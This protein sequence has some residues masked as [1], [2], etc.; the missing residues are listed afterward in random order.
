MS[1]GKQVMNKVLMGAISVRRIRKGIINETYDIETKKKSF[2][3]RVF[4]KDFWKVKKEK[5]LYD[6]IKKKAKV[7]VPKILVA[8][9]N[10]ILMEKVDGKELQITDKQLIRKAG[11][12]LAKLHSIK[13]KHYGWIVEDK[14]KPKFSNWSSFIR[15]DLDQKL[16][17][18]PKAHKSLGKTIKK[19]LDDDNK[20]L[21]IKEKPCLLHK[22]YHSS[23]IIVKDNK[24]NGIID[25]EWAVA[26][27]NEMDLVKSC[28]WM[29]ENKKGLE[30]I[31]L[32]GYKKYGNISED[33][34]ER[35]KLYM[36][37]VLAS[38]LSLSYE[39]KDKKWCMY[40]FDKLKR[41]LN[42]Y[43]E[44]YRAVH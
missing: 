40:N 15:Y 13:F 12:I 38:S 10:Y 35:K 17:K 37:L 8:G 14:I 9:K 36:I 20:L 26:G 24:I 41:A 23:H 2:I 5:Y 6:M 33:F 29:F 11:E 44:T 22:D 7:P 31:F 18:L 25:L 27:H 32:E 30:K 4:P 16:K 39:C 34:K 21:D 42:E 1:G 3:L 19:I 43:N 28:F